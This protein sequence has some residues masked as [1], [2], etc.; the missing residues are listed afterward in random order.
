M[1]QGATNS[2]RYN[3]ADWLTNVGG[4]SYPFGNHGNLTGRG[5][6]SV[7]YDFRR[8]RRAGRPDR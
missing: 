8:P 2:Y 7:G 3:K 5:T 6:D 4:T 1:T